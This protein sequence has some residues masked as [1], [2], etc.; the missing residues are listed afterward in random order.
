MMCGSPPDLDVGSDASDGTPAAH[1]VTNLLAFFLLPEHNCEWDP[2]G[3]YRRSITK[4]L[5]KVVYV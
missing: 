3:Y 1:D 2:A 5:P 4:N